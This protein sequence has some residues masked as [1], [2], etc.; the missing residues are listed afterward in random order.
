MA[1]EEDYRLLVEECPD[2]L[3]IASIDGYFLFINKTWRSVLGY[4]LDDLKSK[5]FMD[6]VHKDDI[7]PTSDLMVDLAR[8]SSE[9]VLF[10]NRYRKADGTYVWLAWGAKNIDGKIYAFAKD[11]TE[12]KT[13]ELFLSDIQKQASIGAWTL[14]VKTL[15]TSWTEQTYRIHE[16][17]LGTPTNTEKGIEFYH[18]DDRGRIRKYVYDAIAKK[19]PY[20]DIFRFI[21]AKGRHIWVRATGGPVL[22][23]KGE[24]TH[25]QGTFQDIDTYQS[26]VTAHQ[27]LEYDSQ[28][29]INNSPA[30][31]YQFQLDPDGKMFFPY[32]S[33]KAFDIY[34]IE[35]Q[36]FKKHPSIMLDMT[37]P[38]DQESLRQKILTSAE[39]MEAFEWSGRIITSMGETRWIKAQSLPRREP[40]GA[41]LWHGHVMDITNEKRL[42]LE[43]LEQQKSLEHQSRLA[44]IGELAAGVG[45]EINNPLAVVMGY[46]HILKEQIKCLDQES[47]EKILPILSRQEAACDR[48][49]N[50]VR[51]LKALSSPVSHESECC[52]IAL[53]MHSCLEFAEEIHGKDILRFQDQELKAEMWVKLSNAKVHQ[54]LTN[55]INNAMDAVHNQAD[56]SITVAIHAAD[57]RFVEIRVTDNGPGIPESIQDKVFQSFFT[58][59]NVGKG[60]GLGL[61]IVHKIIH[62]SGGRVSFTSSPAGTSFLVHIPK[63]ELMSEPAREPAEDFAGR[64]GPTLRIL[65]VD[66]EEDLL[67]IIKTDLETAGQHVITAISAEDALSILKERSFDWVISDIKMPGMSGPDL[68]VAMNT[69]SHLENTKRAFMTGGVIGMETQ[70]LMEAPYYA[71][72]VLPKPFHI[73]D[74]LMLIGISKPQSY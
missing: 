31:I 68:F 62:D 1:T 70:S 11:V 56:K 4:D 7:A 39:Q 65:V 26:L 28:Y 12:L 74:F 67:D 32:V 49:A 2:M 16:V 41:I 24:V 17:E 3:C 45:H 59:K 36:E 43:L 69:L 27:K 20:D 44:S 38:D 54:V 53:S 55:L 46:V 47:R 35:A 58:T 73:Q 15:E 63:V 5:P 6:F 18:P 66:D 40:G 33:S 22:N 19:Q 13:H 14:D 71:S 72:K 25:L 34:Q 37:H 50:I 30:M 9:C 52:D 21:T 23:S 61:S 10:Q 64:S 8:E 42:E 51:G 57:S 60:T 48:M 29:F